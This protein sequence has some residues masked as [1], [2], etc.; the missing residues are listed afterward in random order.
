MVFE[1][2]VLRLKQTRQTAP[3]QRKSLCCSVPEAGFDAVRPRGGGAADRERAH[4][5]SRKRGDG[6]R[7]AQIALQCPGRDSNPH[8]VT[9]KGF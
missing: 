7:K 2:N 8:G 5:A 3:R 9:P 4:R 6:E 1:R